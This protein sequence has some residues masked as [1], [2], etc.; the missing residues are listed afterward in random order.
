[1]IRAET[2]AAVLNNASENVSD[3]V[4]IRVVITARETGAHA[5][6][7]NGPATHGNGSACRHDYNPNQAYSE[8]KH[9]LTFRE[10]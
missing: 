1:M 3:S 5:R 9:S 6:C 4:L 7:G 2:A 8:Y 10:Q